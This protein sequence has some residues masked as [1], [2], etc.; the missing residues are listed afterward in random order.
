MLHRFLPIAALKYV[1]VSLPAAAVEFVRVRGSNT[2]GAGNPISSF[3]R[4]LFTP[5]LHSLHATFTSNGPE[6]N[7]GELSWASRPAQ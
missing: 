4:A 6:F 2:A 3:L 7:R 5:P 1:S